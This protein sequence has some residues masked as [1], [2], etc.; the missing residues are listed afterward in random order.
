VAR[1]KSPQSAKAIDPHRQREAKKYDNPIP[2]R[3]FILETLTQHA[4][5]MAFQEVVDALGLHE[6]Q[7]L[8]ALDRRLGAM[9]RDGQLVRNRRDAYCLVNKRDLVAGRIIAHPD[10]FGF[11]KPDEG[12]DDLYL[13]PKEMRAVFHGDR[14]VA[15]VTGRDRRGRL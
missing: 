15:R 10:G 8:L 2:S 1:R 12:G 11:V 4:A 5:P 14:V 7:D 9:V 6:D 13:Y 3:E